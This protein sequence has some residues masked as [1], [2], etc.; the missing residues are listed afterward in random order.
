MRSRP[1]WRRLSSHCWRRYSGRPTGRQ[2][3]GPARVRPALVAITRPSGYGCR[4]WRMSCSLTNGPYE[5]A[6]S[7]KST[8]RSTARRRT[9]MA[10]SGSAGSP[11]T[12][13]PVSCMAPYP[14]RCTGRS[15][16]RRKVPERWTGRSSGIGA[17]F[18]WGRNGDATLL[19][20][21]GAARGVGAPRPCPPRDPH[22]KVSGYGD[23]WGT[24]GDQA[25]GGGGGRGGDHGQHLVVRPQATPQGQ[26]R[27]ERVRDRGWEQ[28]GWEEQLADQ[29]RQHV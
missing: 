18:G 24:E 1:R 12:P 17:P 8:P 7:M 25:G 10:S 13:G 29:L 26:G 14:R 28:R 5:S 23:E 3:A 19:A 15:P 22:G 27:E 21:R 20:R 6:V 16:P 4:A 2:S 9:R 11:Q